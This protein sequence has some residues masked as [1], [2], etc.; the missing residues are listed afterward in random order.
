MRMKPLSIRD[1]LLLTIGTLALIITFLVAQQ[2]YV[3][4]Q[5]LAQIQSLKNA[6]V[7]SD[8]LFDATEKLSEERDI[9]YTILHASDQETIDSLRA[10]LE[11]SGRVADAAF[12]AT[13][14]ALNAYDFPEI[15]QLRGNM[16]KQ[17]SG[18]QALRQQILQAVAMPMAR[19]NSKLS[20]QWFAEST[21]LIVQ[22]QDIWV[23]FT[24][25]FINIDPI[26]TQHLRYKH[27]LRVISDYTGRE[28]AII[29]RLIVE[30]AD[31]T[32]DEF[33]QLLRGQ[34]I[35][36][37]SWKFMDILA[38]QSGLY[39]AITP[40][41]KDARSHYQTLYDMVRDIFYVSGGRRNT[42]SPIGVDLWFELSAQAKESFDALKEVSLKEIRNHVEMLEMQAERSILIH[43][44]LLLVALML[45][46]YS[47]RVIIHRVIH[48]I[49]TMVEA[50]VNATQGKTSAM[51]PLASR[52]DEIGKLAY[53]LRTFQDM[54]NHIPDPIF[55]KDRQHRWI[56]G[57]K[58]FWA[59]MNGPPE[60]FIGKSD[61]DF[62]P[63]EEADAFW[64]KDNEAFNCGD[65]LINEES[66]TDSKGMRHVLSTKKI[67]FHNDKSEMYLIG[68]IRDITSAK[69]AQNK[70]MHYTKALERSNKELDDFAYIASHDLKE[71]LRGLFNH[72]TFLLEDYQ[73]KLDADGVHKLHRLSYL[74]QR[75]ER[76]VN[77][78]L[79]FSRLG[80]QDLAIQPTDINEVIHDIANTLDLFLE[81]RHAHIVIPKPLPTVTC[82]KIRI[83]EVFRNLITNAIK[84]NNKPEKMV[85]I[86]FLESHSLPDGQTARN[87][88][89][90]K[91][92]GKGIPEEFYEEIFRIFK[93]LQNT[94]GTQE[95]GT[96]VGL[97]FV[98][99]I[100]ERHGGKI[101]LESEADKGTIFY[102]TLRA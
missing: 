25:H 27:F 29:G 62:F 10:R 6:V 90:V 5:R 102:F 31:P 86:G 53:V 47:F 34:G 84:Y 22:T 78:L 36:D 60:K 87:I 44:V 12:V 43:I 51:P 32:P 66:F 100:I 77:D 91:D 93:R 28:R 75:M 69:E 56:G 30:N 79:Y 33:A 7:M 19:R 72:A 46:A 9:A 4:W 64:Q 49:N 73:D 48:P 50:L 82:D 57:N 70:L 97:T 63:K 101:W 8:Q 18:I 17:L 65:E 71:P 58:A 40:Y 81:E 88:F 26:V 61:Y 38:N 14:S 1:I 11:A 41:Y 37:L 74:A 95:E 35:I 15:I 94:K 24:R 89:Y 2:V 98:K 23:E 83:T 3:N 45:C 42:S 54:L 99:K 59:L 96:G 20:N 39:P 92:D 80:R 21:G 13:M 52:D 76:L 55:M 85:E 67:A 68:V 16:E